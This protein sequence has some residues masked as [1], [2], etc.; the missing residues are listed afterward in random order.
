[1]DAAQ[2]HIDGNTPQ[3][4][5]EHRMLHKDGSIRWI[6]C[7]GIATRDADG[8]A[9]RMFGTDM[10]ITERKTAEL[11]RDKL[12]RDLQDALERIKQL[13][14]LLPICSVCKKIR[15]EDGQWHPLENYIH[16]HSEADFSHGLCPGCYQESMEK[17]DNRTGE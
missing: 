11:E 1:M 9:C 12:V 14:G 10:D 13:S 15:D 6:L 16:E 2:A 17:L 3:Y 4:V 5:C 8:K 7:R